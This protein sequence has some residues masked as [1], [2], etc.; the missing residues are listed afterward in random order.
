[1]SDLAD[2]LE[3]LHEASDGWSTLG[4]TI[5]SRRHT[6]VADRAYELWR[7][8]VRAH[9]R[10]MGGVFASGRIG[11][12]ASQ[13]EDVQ[14][15]WWE[16]RQRL[17]IAKPDRLRSETLYDVQGRSQLHLW[18]RHGPDLWSRIPAHGAEHDRIEAS[19]S[20][21]V[22]GQELFSPETLLLR[23]LSARGRGTVDGREVIRLGVAPPL[24]GRWMQDGIGSDAVTGGSCS[25]ADDIEVGVDVATGVLLSVVARLEGFEFSARE[26]SDLAVDEPLDAGLFTFAPE[27]GEAVAEGRHRHRNL[28]PEEVADVPFPIL[29]PTLPF[30][31]FLNIGVS[32][33]G[34]SA[35]ASLSWSQPPGMH[36]A[37]V[38]VWERAASQPE[39][40]SEGFEEIERAGERLRVRRHPGHDGATDWWAVE[41]TRAGTRARLQSSLPREELIELA[42][43]LH[44][45][46]SGPPR[47]VDL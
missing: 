24:P 2:A 16:S 41:I 3:L 12:I 5:V 18:I 46:V 44:P 10:A 35:L 45:F 7:E 27:P 26:V 23:E 32:G 30:L 6:E 42:L 40:D 21:T 13:G 9:S 17:W 29:V 43:G 34:G 20:Y 33:E 4:C 1:M 37:H 31:R 38:N 15:E 11:M 22:G 39:P 47:L 36:G 28:Q 19:G 8:R 14:P 25:G